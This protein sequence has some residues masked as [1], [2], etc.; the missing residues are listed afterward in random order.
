MSNESIELTSSSVSEVS[1]HDGTAHS[2]VYQ[3][4]FELIEYKNRLAATKQ[5]MAERG[6]DLLVC[7]DPCNMNYLTGYDGWSFHTPQC[8]LVSLEADEPVWIGRGVDLFGAQLTSYLKHENIE[9]YPDSYFVTHTDTHPFNFI[10]DVVKQRHWDKGTI[11]LETE[12]YGLNARSDAILKSDLSNATFTNAQWL[13]DWIRAIKSRAEVALMDEAARILEN[14]MQTVF[15][16]IA[17]GVRQCDLAAQVYS[18]QVRGTDD[19]HGD[20]PSVVPLMPS[21]AGTSAPHLTWTNAKYRRDEATIVEIAGCRYRYHTPMGRTVFL[22]TPPQTMV[23]AAKYAK[24]GINAAIEVIKPGVHCE[25]VEAA[26][27]RA[28]AGSGF[29]KE[30]RVGY[31]IGIGYPPDW[32]GNIMSFYPGDKSVLQAGMTFHVM[33]GVWMHGWGIEISEPIQVT[34]DGAR[35]FADVPRDLIVKAC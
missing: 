13:V 7:T 29:S 27:R 1:N 25:E 33:P 19:F 16:N 9:P 5:K 6:I 23:D 3:R 26:W 4:P 28:V 35:L 15:A 20:Y 11:G 24:D 31:V 10:A 32:C 14:A 2:T 21:G 18:A 12:T 22:G 34:D 30:S 8:A 17:P